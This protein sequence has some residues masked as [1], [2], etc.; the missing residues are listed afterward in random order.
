VVEELAPFLLA[1]TADKKASGDLS[2][3]FSWDPRT[4][5]GPSPGIAAAG[6]LTMPG[7][8]SSFVRERPRA[9]RFLE[10]FACQKFT[11]PPPALNLG[12]PGV[13]IAKTGTCQH[14]HK[15]MDPVAVAFKR[16]DYDNS[17]YIPWAMLVDVGPWEITQEELGGQYP[18]G[19][20]PFSRWVSAWIPGTVLT[21][22]TEAE[23]AKNPGAIAFD[24][25]PKDY[26][27]LGVHPDGTTGP[28]GFGK[29]LVTSGAFDRCAAQRLYERFI[30]HPLD[31]EREA[32]YIEALG[33][34]FKKGGRKVRPFVKSLFGKAEFRR[35]L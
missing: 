11:P 15:L 4:D 28:L 23:A 10:I 29:V 33:E 9:A 8:N 31:P 13:D 18:Y 25:I 34:E 20:N 7:V 35:G 26:E 22:I 14:C 30:G 5:M 19:G 24:T 32:L 27:I 21:P 1:A 17:N 2:R 12:P 16:W 6:V 3:Q